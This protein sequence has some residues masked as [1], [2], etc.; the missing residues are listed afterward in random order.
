VKKP[1]HVLVFVALVC[2]VAGLGWSSLRPVLVK[3]TE[4][5]VVA[6]P[7]KRPVS[8]TAETCVQKMLTLRHKGVAVDVGTHEGQET[9]P[10]AQAGNEVYS[11]EPMLKT[12]KFAL[13]R[14]ETSGL[15]K[16]V[17]FRNIAL[18]DHAGSMLVRVTMKNLETV[19]LSPKRES[20][21]MIG[22]SDDAEFNVS[23]S[24]MDEE[25]LS[26]LVV[27]CFCCFSFVLLQCPCK[28]CLS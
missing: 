12:Y 4:S 15:A 19:Q 26:D 25:G 7:V 17:H 10:L 6:K 14:L 22:L 28:K 1:H 11:F 23:L 9:L 18:S 13:D 21:K 20:L 24:T 5:P 8:D 27:V 3:V 2:I 16:R